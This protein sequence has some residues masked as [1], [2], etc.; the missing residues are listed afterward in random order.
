MEG[1][2][3]RWDTTGRW[4]YPPLYS[5]MTEVGLEEVE[6]YVLRLQNTIA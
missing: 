2:W 1:I 5:A 4:V 6:K 3:T